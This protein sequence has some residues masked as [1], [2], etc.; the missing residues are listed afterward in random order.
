MGMENIFEA[1]L[2]KYLTEGQLNAIRCARIGIGGA[3][4]LGSNVALILIR[5]G[6]KHLEILDK[7]VVEA[8]NLNRQDYTLDDIGKPKVS[9][10]KKRLLSI[11]P[12]AH[13][14]IHHQEWTTANTDQFLK[15]ADIIVEAFDK[16][17]VKSTF[18]EYYAP[19]FPYV[20]SGNGMS[21]IKL[22]TSS[23]TLRQVGNIFL[24][25]DGATSIE[26]GHPSLAPRVIQCAAKMAEIVLALVLSKD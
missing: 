25:G 6:F 20:V 14:V 12:D 15:D 18:V 11:N 26:D 9:C 24:V 3:G 21:G 19:R 23:T 10:L 22:N 5:T 7:D 4:G 2:R 17:I 13:I 16:A 1:A 8:S